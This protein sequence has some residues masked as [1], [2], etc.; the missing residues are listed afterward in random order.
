MKKIGLI[1]KSLYS[2]Q[3]V[4]D[5]RKNP[6]YLALIIFILSVFLPWIPTLSSGYTANTASLLTSTAN[7]E[8]DKGIKATI[9]KDYFKKIMI[10]KDGENYYFSY[11]FEE[12]DY[13]LT[14]TAVDFENEYNGTNDKELYK[15]V[16]SDQGEGNNVNYYS[17]V[18][19]YTKTHSEITDQLTYYYD[20]ISVETTNQIDPA[21][22]ATSST[23]SD[24]I[25]YE[26]GRTTY[27]ENYYFPELSMKTATYGTYLN[28]FVSSAVLRM[29]ENNAA[30][31]YPHSYAIWAKDFVLI[32]VYPLK[33]TKSNISVS[34]SFAGDLNDAII[35]KGI[36][37]GTSF[38]NYL[39]DNGDSKLSTAYTDK[40]ASFM[41]EAGRKSYITSTWVNIG[42]LSA[43][44][45]GCI[46]VA[47]LL[48]LW[49]NKSKS[50]LYRESN[51]FHSLNEAIYM[52]LS[53]SLIGMVIG[54]FLSSYVYVIMIGAILMRVIFSRNKICPPAQMDGSS[55][56]PLYQARS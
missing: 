43:V 20:N 28:N 34:G 31:R 42:V 50:S 40:F 3:A 6:W 37:D 10:K 27:L 45:A 8:L 17:S 44:V 4:I 1:F 55:N 52:M 47:S 39:T 29:D 54:F 14:S 38:Y 56:K 48:L 11:N 33:S 46:L 19:K 35:N 26:T 5:S 12:S 2:N 7:Q 32:A 36:V 15:G 49:F 51:Y 13:T 30:N 21:S 9:E 25:V 22:N 53:P 16:F 41:H 23:S 18:T 24:S